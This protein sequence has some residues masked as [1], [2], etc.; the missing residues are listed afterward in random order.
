[1]SKPSAKAGTKKNGKKKPLP[2]EKVADMIFRMADHPTAVGRTPKDGEE[3]YQ[4]MLPLEDGRK[5]LILFG[6]DTLAR[7]TDALQNI[8]LDKVPRVLKKA[9]SGKGQIVMA[10][11]Y[12]EKPG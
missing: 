1:M 6:D 3:G 11:S 4:L 2:A 7:L 8:Y 12:M 9:V 5:I 10:E